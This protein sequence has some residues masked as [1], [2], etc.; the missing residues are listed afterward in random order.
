MRLS[1]F[2]ALMDQEFGPAYARTVA[3]SHA[4]HALGDQTAQQAL[5]DGVPPR[6]IWSALVHDFEISQPF[7][8]PPKR[9]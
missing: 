4:I 8:A 3:T 6:R 5:D 2:W 1:E 7:L 9:S